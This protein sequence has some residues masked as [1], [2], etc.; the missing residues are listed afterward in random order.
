MSVEDFV[1]S[2]PFDRR[3]YRQ[4]IWGSIAHVSMLAKC[5]ILDDQDASAIIDG[6]AAI[7]ADIESGKFP[8]DSRDEDV[9]MAIERALIDK[10]GA[11]GGRLHT[12]RSRN[13][14]IVLDLRL[15]L[16]GQIKGVA[17][18]ILKLQTALKSKAEENLTLVMPGYTHL[19]PAQP[20][21]V[22]QH[23][24]A[25][26]FMLKRDFSRVSDCYRRADVMP[27]GAAA[28]AGTGFPVDRDY[29]AEKL[30]FSQVSENSM[31]TVAD[32]DFVVEF[33]AA[34]ALTM[35]HLSRLAEELIIWSSVEFDF[36]ELDDAFV[37]GS[38]IMPQKRNPDVA[39]LVRGKSGRVFGDLMQTLAVLKG[40][41]LAYNRDLQ[42]DKEALFDTLDTLAPCL[43]MTSGMISSVKVKAERLKQAVGH[44]F[45]TAT[46]LADYL[47]G[48]GVPFREA[49]RLVGDLVKECLANDSD[50][51]RLDLSSLQ[52]VS[53]HF[54]EDA[55]S[56]LD[57]VEAVER[58]RSAGGTAS[59]RVR[60]QLEAGAKILSDEK[61]WLEKLIVEPP[62]LQELSETGLS[63]E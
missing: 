54:A 47:V 46:D 29:L 51:S 52:K 17:E 23:L 4:D 7:F 24:M 10:I 43:E 42:E 48:K 18:G 28:L 14:Q 34:A 30:G 39:E 3:L 55:L 31:D 63:F 11:V 61:R 5:S 9:H 59:V 15:Y 33:L 8:F 25:Y 45:M 37:T 41:P 38:S 19:Q 35:V 6:L 20:V 27:L 62:L 49:H 44:G 50:F 56:L 36:I 26:F 58:R 57:P 22:S 32:R 16:K 60:E 1:A 21:L 2:L 40:L 13:D 53:P 12:G